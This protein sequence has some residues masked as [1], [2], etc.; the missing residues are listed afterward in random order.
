MPLLWATQAVN[1]LAT[2]SQN[3]PVL[4]Q[5]LN[6]KGALVKLF[7]LLE[8]AKDDTLTLKTIRALSS[9]CSGNPTTSQVFGRIN[10]RKIRG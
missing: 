10:T 8:E 6:E 3:H 5:E 1:C 7:N 9:F 2:A 4:Q